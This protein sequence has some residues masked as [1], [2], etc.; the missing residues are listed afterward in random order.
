MR[1][2]QPELRR[3]RFNGAEILRPRKGGR[4]VVDGVTMKTASMGPRSSDLGKDASFT[5]SA[6]RSQI[7]ARS[8]GREAACRSTALWQRLV[9]P[10]TNQRAK[11]GRLASHLSTRRGALTRLFAALIFVVAAYMLWQSAPLLG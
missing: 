6:A 10:P 4:E 9:V 3:L 11:G 8:A 5:Q 1:R 7:S 2:R